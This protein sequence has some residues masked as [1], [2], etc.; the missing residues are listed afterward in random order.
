MTYGSTQVTVAT[1]GKLTINVSPA[2]ADVTNYA[3]RITRSIFQHN[4]PSGTPTG[5]LNTI[6]IDIVNVNVPLQI[7]VDETYTL[8]IPTSGPIVITANTVYGA[9]WALQTLSQ[10][11]QFD[12]DSQ[13]YVVTHAPYKIVDGPKLPFRA[14]LID[15]DR[16]WQPLRKIYEIIDSMIMTKLNVLH[17]HIVDEQSWPL[18]SKQYPLLWNAAWSPSE[19]YT[20]T[21]LEMIYEYARAR[22]VLVMPEFDTPGH[23]GSICVGYPE[24]CPSTTCTMPLNPTTNATFDLI[25]A[26]LSELVSIFPSNYFHLGGDE[27]DTSC[28]SN[29]P[30]IVAWMSA[31]NLTTDTTYEYFVSRV[32]SITESLNRYPVRWE[33]VWN[34][35]GTQLSPETVIHCWLS[36]ECVQNVTFHGRN[37]LYAVDGQYY[38]DDLTETWDSF[39]DIDPLAPLNGNQ[40]AVPFMLGASV[41]MWGETADGSDVISTIWP[42]A[43]SAAE[44][45]WSYDVVTNSSDPNV[46]VRFEDFRCFM[47]Y[48][49][50]GSAPVLNANAR[51]GPPG[52]G[53]CRRQ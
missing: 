41:S 47:L 10:L 17:F 14:L 35:F 26:V 42:R 13:T 32:D 23:A 40:S 24:V 15:T 6:N 45:W 33:E 20:L 7:G 1:L 44:R 8:N 50:I 21:D 3:D 29:T 39:Y 52:P 37:A 28:W 31:N 36:E 4:L 16:H 53:S 49:G 38:L 48:N 34:H 30:S 18:Q 51:T 43:A 9:Y 5:T 2:S 46:L 19:R 25:T 12:F 11:V 22:G 27:V